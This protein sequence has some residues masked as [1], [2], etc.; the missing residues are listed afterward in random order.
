MARARCSE[1]GRPRAEGSSS[2]EDVPAVQG[3]GD[4]GV[5]DKAWSWRA[6]TGVH[7]Q[8]NVTRAWQEREASANGSKGG[9]QRTC[10]AARCLVLLV[11]G[12]ARGGAS[13]GSRKRVVMN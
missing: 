8:D 1:R 2:W 3:R 10:L 9:K 6:R 12:K 13:L 4:S 11:M 5:E 7:R